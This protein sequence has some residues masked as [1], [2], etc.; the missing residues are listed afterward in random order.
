MS[1]RPEL[2]LELRRPGLEMADIAD[3]SGPTGL[4][5]GRL[6][7]IPVGDGHVLH[8]LAHEEI[9]ELRVL[10]EVHAPASELHVIERRNRDVDVPRSKSSGIVR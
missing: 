2:G 5:Q 9:L 7:L 3:E 4:G 10:L 1:S 6:A 8:T